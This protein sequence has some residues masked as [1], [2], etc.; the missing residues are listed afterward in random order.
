[1]Q[2][3]LDVYPE[4]ARMRNEIGDLPLHMALRRGTSEAIMHK[5]FDACPE[6][7]RERNRN[8]DLP[9]H[10][11]LRHKAPEELRV[12]AFAQILRAGP[13]VHESLDDARF[14]FIRPRAVQLLVEA[15][16]LAGH[17][18]EVSA[19]EVV[20]ILARSAAANRDQSGPSLTAMAWTRPTTFL[21]FDM[22]LA[23]VPQDDIK[24]QRFLREWHCAELHFFRCFERGLKEVTTGLAAHLIATMVQ[25]ECTCQFCSNRK[26]GAAGNTSVGAG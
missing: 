24:A 19:P 10:L 7:A 14:A 12:G 22:A 18:S 8:G 23:A 25:G 16:H 2:K 13:P 5:V 20:A 4:A 9:L 21:N 17:G 11:A 26:R 3:V 15:A 6:A 1:M